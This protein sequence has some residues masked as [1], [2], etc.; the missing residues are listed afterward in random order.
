M[1]VSHLLLCFN[2][3]LPFNYD[4]MRVIP[5][6]FDLPVSHRLRESMWCPQ[7]G[8]VMLYV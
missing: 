7:C 6:N 5:R 8:E 4:V 2:E 3:R 1:C